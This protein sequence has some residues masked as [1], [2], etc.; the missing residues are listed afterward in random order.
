MYDLIGDIHGHATELKALLAKMD[1]QEV[2]G[3]WQHPVRKVIFLGDFVDRGPEQVETLR[4]AKAMVD[5]GNGL[6]VMGNHEFNAV[7]WASE[8]PQNPGKFLRPHTEKNLEQ[9]NEFLKQ[10]VEG[11][12][13]HVEMIEWFKTLPIYL[14]LPELRV[15]HACW[16]PFHLEEISAFTDSENQL[17]TDSW[18]RCNRE[19]SVAFGAIET[20]LKGLELPL[21]EG[22]YF[23]DRSGCKRRN[24]RTKWWDRGARTYYDLALVPGSEIEK[25]PD[26]AVDA[27]KLPGYDNLKPVFVG[28]YWFRGEPAPLTDHIACLDYSVAKGSGGKLCAYRFN[29]CQT[30]QAANF[31]W[32]DV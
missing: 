12:L 3:V 8:D 31:V 32:V 1:Y 24:I 5:T 16:H 15:I 23:L 13:L 6:A 20:L 17:L 28:H 18:E 25:I 21:P 26:T 29:N 10:V 27:N 30:I 22:H 14:D 11:S 9:H 2:D 19:G 7:A 4:I